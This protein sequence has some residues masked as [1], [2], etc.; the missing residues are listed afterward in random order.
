MGLL[1]AAK[2]L[3]NPF[4]NAMRMARK[5]GLVLASTLLARAHGERP[6][7]LVGFSLGGK[8]VW[9]CCREL[10]RKGGY[11][12][13]ENVVIIGAPV[14]ADE[15]DWREV[16]SVVS[17]RVVN[18]YSEKDWILGFLYRS[19]N[20]QL[21]VAGLQ[22]VGLYGVENVN[23]AERVS[24]HL[25]YRFEVPFIL[26]E[27]LGDDVKF[28]DGDVPSAPKTPVEEKDEAVEEA[29]FGERVEMAE[30]ELEMRRKEKEKG[31]KMD[32]KGV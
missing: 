24:G 28:E 18:V 7:T 1:K 10:S 15:D 25:K 26:R 6:I 29:E 23:V 14:P 16:R 31:G 2:L 9:E 20:L 30:K 8:V 27:V 22:E 12:I 3:D 5:T 17:G 32:E 21:G 19:A 13:I 11:G 4:A